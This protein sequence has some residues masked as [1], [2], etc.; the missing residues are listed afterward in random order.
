MVFRPQSLSASEGAILGVIACEEE[1]VQKKRSYATPPNGKKANLP[2]LGK[3]KIDPPPL[4][5]QVAAK[6]DDDMQRL[7]L[8][9]LITYS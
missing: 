1:E 4:V 9:V 3:G 8:R 2:F 5:L 7:F 6:N